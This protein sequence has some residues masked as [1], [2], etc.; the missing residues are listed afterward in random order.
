[1]VWIVELP[2]RGVL[3]VQGQDCQSFL[4]GLITQDLAEIIPDKVGYSLFLNAQ[5]RYRYQFFLVNRPKDQAIDLLMD[6][7]LVP[8]LI[9]LLSPYR[10]RAKVTL[11]DASNLY[12]TVAMGS[13][14]KEDL[15]PSW[16]TQPGNLLEI[17]G[18][19]LEGS[20]FQDPRC[21]D[22]GFQMLISKTQDL[23]DVKDRLAIL[24]DVSLQENQ[25]CMYEALRLGLGIPEHQDLVFEK[26][27]PLECGFR[28][29]G[30]IAWHKGCYLGQEPVAR[31]HY[32]GTIRKRLLPLKG[33][34][35]LPEK[36]S[37][38][39]YKGKPAGKIGSGMVLPNSQGETICLGLVRLEAFFEFEKDQTP[40]LLEESPDQSFLPYRAIW[41]EL[42]PPSS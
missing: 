13:Q 40:F 6:T 31:A 4:N 12:Q 11:E 22:L 30:A 8:D 3:R 18:Q 28:E 5:G 32:Q 16:P 34:G 9:A 15:P 7:S 24:L 33:K 17:S 41:M 19:G 27:I 36:G 2:Q 26:S 37:I 1:M 42:T 20:L 10:L 29:L 38:L 39:R 21:Q 23:A 14:S 25:L 35:P